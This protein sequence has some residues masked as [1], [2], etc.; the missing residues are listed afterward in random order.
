M[1]VNDF[2][3]VYVSPTTERREYHLA[4]FAWAYVKCLCLEFIAKA[5]TKHRSQLEELLT[6]LETCINANRQLVYDVDNGYTT[7]EILVH[8]ITTDEGLL[9]PFASWR[10]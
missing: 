5:K 8:S 10:D 1:K 9:A 2:P 7:T 4:D 3:S 6:D